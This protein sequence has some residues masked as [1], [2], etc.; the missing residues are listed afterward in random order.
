[1]SIRN[2]T[3]T[4][5]LFVFSTINKD[6]KI[7]NFSW[8]F[9]NLEFALDALNSLVAKGNQ[10]I[11]IELIEDE[12]R[13]KLP[14]GAFDGESISFTIKSLENEWLNLLKEPIDI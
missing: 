8:W 5:M 11:S 9:N 4:T 13:T 2:I 10:I 6:I 12:Q 14:A 7:R 3:Q 1:M